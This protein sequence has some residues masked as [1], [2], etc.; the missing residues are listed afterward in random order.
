MNALPDK[1]SLSRVFRMQWEETQ[2]NYVLLYPD[3]M[4]KLN[5]SAAEILKRCDGKRS[6]PAIVA[7]LEQA[8][9][10]SGLRDDVDDFLRAANERGWLA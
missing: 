6:V 3:G 4:V 10:A 9:G 7:E 8:F 2:N 1:P 5:G